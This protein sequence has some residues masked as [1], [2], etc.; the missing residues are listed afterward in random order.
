M[1]I[2]II[3]IILAF[4]FSAC[5][6][7]ELKGDL[8]ILQGKWKWTETYT[9]PNTRKTPSSENYNLY[10]EFLPEGNYV[11]YKNNEE[12]ESGRVIIEEKVDSVNFEIEFNKSGFGDSF[13]LKEF[14]NPFNNPFYCSSSK[15]DSM[16]IYL[17]IFPPNYINFARK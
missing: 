3:L 8:E 2:I 9:G 5:K 1:K 16:K 11:L 6:K 7:T 4:T 13:I 15:K 10:L 14:V 17:N 12:E